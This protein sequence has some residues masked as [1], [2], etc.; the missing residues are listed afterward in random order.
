MYHAVDYKKP[1]VIRALAKAGANM[2]FRFPLHKAIN[3]LDHSCVAELCASGANVN[4]LDQNNESP[5]SYAIIAGNP[6]AIKTL[7]K[8]KANVNE[9]VDNETLLH[10]AIVMYH[11]V[12]ENKKERKMCVLAMIEAGP[13]FKLLNIWGN[14]AAE[15]AAEK[16]MP[17]IVIQIKRAELK[18]RFSSHA[19]R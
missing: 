15:D 4:L 12:D 19:K 2:N 9:I 3:S 18:Q 10:Y 11:V 13:N 16:N 7:T 5:L 8:Y 1:N 17:D 14:T 6:E